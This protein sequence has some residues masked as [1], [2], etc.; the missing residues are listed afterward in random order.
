MPNPGRRSAPSPAITSW[1][2]SVAF[3]PDGRRL[4]SGSV[5]KT[6]RLWDAESGQEIRSFAGH[7]GW[8]SRASPFRPTADACSPAATT[9]R[10]ASGMP[11]PGTRSAPWPGIR[12]WI[13]SVAFSPDGRRLLS[14][15]VDKTLRLWDAESGHE[16]RSF[17]GHQGWISSV[18]FS[19]DGRR[20]LSGSDDQ[21]LRLWDA[22]SGQEIRSFAG[23]QG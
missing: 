15:S 3:S 8:V 18:A 13:S 1:I 2:S 16:I 7:Q 21:T 12:V 19:P 23:H 11:N 4:L 6:L 14:G 17:A 5:D 20:L 10:Y 22:E 9:R